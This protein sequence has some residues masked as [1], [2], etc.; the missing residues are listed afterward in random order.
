MQSGADPQVAVATLD[1]WDRAI[2]D[3]REEL[4]RIL[5]E[6]GSLRDLRDFA[7]REC[8]YDGVI[9]ANWV[10]ANTLHLLIQ[11]TPPGEQFLELTYTLAGDPVILRD[12]FPGEYQSDAPVWMYD[13]ISRV[14][15]GPGANG[16][17]VFQHNVLLG[18]GW[19]LCVRFVHLKATRVSAWFPAPESAQAALASTALG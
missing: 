18:N 3:Y 10:A 11:P 19:E 7:E 12:V 1:E 4:T 8:L 16:E 13:E 2:A 9:V 6:D 15:Q 5:P 14:N 17:P